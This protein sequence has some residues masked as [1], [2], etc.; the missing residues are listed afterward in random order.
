MYANLNGNQTEE[1]QKVSYVQKR[2]AE[3]DAISS[4]NDYIEDKDTLKYEKECR[5]IS[6]TLSIVKGA[7]E[8]GDIQKWI[9]Y[10]CTTINNIE[11]MK[12]EFCEE[13][14]SNVEFID[15][16]KEIIKFHK[17]W[18]C[19]NEN[20]NYQT[21]IGIF[22]CSKCGIHQNKFDLVDEYE[23]CSICKTELTGS[24]KI[25]IN[26][27]NHVYCRQCI[28]EKIKKSGSLLCPGYDLIMNEKCQQIIKVFIFL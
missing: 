9:C 15:P 7:Y 8:H 20:C 13:D 6:K 19:P 24:N 16:D 5:N 26:P 4:N 28:V 12:C 3:I 2:I 23:K 21:E 14:K 22:N 11:S 25:V 1:I 17:Y 27:C 18:P 10:F